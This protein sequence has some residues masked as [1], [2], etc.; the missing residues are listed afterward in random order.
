MTFPFDEYDTRSRLFPALLITLPILSLAFAAAPSA[1]NFVGVGVGTL[2]EGAILYF[3]SRVARDQGFKIQKELFGKWGGP[4]TTRMLRHRDLHLDPTT[5]ARL[6]V[7]LAKTCGI[8][9]PAEQEE[10]SDPVQA[11]SLYASAVRS[12]LE[13]RRDKKQHRLIFVENCNYGFAR[14]LFGMRKAGMAVALLC[15]VA[16]VAVW[17]FASLKPALVVSGAISLATLL[18]LSAYVNEGFVR[19][20]ADAY[21]EALLRSCEPSPAKG[22]SSTRRSTSEKH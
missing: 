14:N 4:P 11:D 3:L 18:L 12:L 9:F 6:K 20:S 2:L 16:D 22:R 5:K 17:H 7:T 10:Q 1:R 8:K 15:G 21:A 19:R 13:Q